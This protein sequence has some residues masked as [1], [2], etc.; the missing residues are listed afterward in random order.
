MSEVTCV[1]SG[2]CNLGEGPVWNVQQHKLYWTDI[3][4]RRIWRFDPK[5]GNSSI[6]WEGDLQVGGFAFTRSGEVVLCSDKG[7]YLIPGSPSACT[8]PFRL[9]DIPLSDNE[10]FN[11]ITVDPKGR[12][13]AGT[14][15]RPDFSGGRL[16][17]LEKGKE[18]AVVLKDLYC[19]NGMSFSLDERTFFHTDSI[20]RRI[21]KYDYDRETGEISN[22][23]V[24]FQGTPEMGSPDGLTMDREGFIWAAFWG[25]FCVRRLDPEGKVAAE[26]RLPAKQISSVMFGGAK[27]NELYVTSACEGAQDTLTG[28]DK[29]GV[30]LGGHLYRCIPGVFG[31]EEWL[32]DF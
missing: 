14:L 1:H 9:F 26:I 12:L 15:T 23:K 21:T 29:D 27:L 30:F 2:I 20:F 24:Y 31:R 7:V 10:M 32:A 19:S 13:F 3:F 5:T 28:L 18:P 22:P 4:N 8:K 17:R 25:G 6:F 11:D 16:Y